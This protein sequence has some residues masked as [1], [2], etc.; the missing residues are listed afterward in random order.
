MPC[1]ANG[2]RVE[3]FHSFFSSYK[4]HIFYVRIRLVGR[5]SSSQLVRTQASQ[6]PRKSSDRKYLVRLTSLKFRQRFRTYFSMSSKYQNK[7][8]RSFYSI[9]DLNRTSITLITWDIFRYCFMKFSTYSNSDCHLSTV[10]WD[11]WFYH[12]LFDEKHFKRLQLFRN[13]QFFVLKLLNDI[14]TIYIF[15]FQ[16]KQNS[17]SQN[18][19]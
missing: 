4:C 18:S 11:W 6:H 17:L 8:N 15:L 19:C 3:R 2:N 9:F 12:E 13:P 7:G 10:G 16:F 14:R 5:F 1:G